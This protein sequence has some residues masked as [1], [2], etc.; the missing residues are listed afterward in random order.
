MFQRASVLRT[1]LSAACLAVF[2]IALLGDDSSGKQEPARKDL[3]GDSLPSGALAR[4]GTLRWRHGAKVTYVACLPDGKGVITADAENV[5]RL[6]DRET[7]KEIRRFTPPENKGSTSKQIEN[8]N[9]VLMLGG[10]MGARQTVALSADGKF[11]AAAHPGLPVQL[12]DVATGKPV[13]DIKVPPGGVGEFV[14]TADSKLIVGRGHDDTTYAWETDTGK[15]VSKIKLAKSEDGGQLGG[16]LLPQGYWPAGDLS[17]SPDGSNIAW[18]ETDFGNG[19]PTAHILIAERKTGK[20]VRRIKLDANNFMAAVLAFSPD[21]KTFAYATGDALHLCAADS[22]KEL[23][24]IKDLGGLSLILF[25]PDSKTLLT[26]G[27][28]G[29]I[30]LWNAEKREKVREID[31]PVPP[32][33]MFGGVF[34]IGAGM[35]GA[36]RDIAFASDGK[37]IAV[38]TGHAV[39]F[40]STE[41]GKEVSKQTGHTSPVTQVCTAADGK[42]ILSRGADGTIRRWDASTG[43]ELSSFQAPAGTSC[44]AASPDGKTVALGNADNT[45]RVCDAAS[46]KE[47]QKIA[48]PSTGVA[49]VAFSRDGKAVAARGHGKTNLG[50]YEAATGKEIKSI[51]FP[52]ENPGGLGGVVF[53][54]QGGG[55]SPGPALIF[56]PDGSTL[57]SLIGTSPV[58]VQPGANEA[59]S[60]ELFHVATGKSRKIEL[61]KE[62]VPAH[63]VYSPDGRTLAVEHADGSATIVEVASGHERCHLV[64]AV[65]KPQPTGQ[66]GDVMMVN[67]IG[68]FGGIG[69]SE[70]VAPKL[71]FAPDGRK[72]AL[73]QGREIT[74]FDMTTG[75]AIKSIKGHDGSITSLAFAPDGK[76][77]ATG[78]SD[79][80]LLLW[81]TS[82]L[83]PNKTVATK[84]GDKEVEAAWANL[85]ASDA[86]KADDSIKALVS[87]RQQATDWLKRYLTPLTPVEKSILEKR[88]AE[89]DSEDFE[90]RTKAT[91]DLEKLGELAVPALEKALAAKPSLEVQKRL[92]ELID[93]TVGGFHTGDRLRIVRAIE[94]LEKIDS[95]EAR[96]L[97]ESLA[98]GAP[99]ALQTENAQDALTRMKK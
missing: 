48:G 75:K 74:V 94:V 53:L 67:V 4:L 62:H 80:T 51:T 99:G 21:G 12:W 32:P 66:P 40:F 34:F 63:I 65:N 70:A 19:Q 98:K 33:S 56:S 77:L 92:E 54:G 26:R 18:V 43:K 78:S 2:G 49:V 71:A 89:L 15:E 88:I 36:T 11:L 59:A 93:K 20:E 1:T 58:F 68:G 37:T 82:D 25:S 91:Q 69:G 10:P 22:G 55:A 64:G 72:L 79:T 73:A 95:P 60:I 96:E 39:R 50:I 41:S 46:G 38:G 6:W 27:G 16:L 8:F 84:L 28:D 86:A 42:T 13:R 7:G 31:C 35:M 44:F 30:I 5:L 57:A 83:L 87:S 52:E 45:V 23:N 9:Q 85:E 81:D 97:L 90:T 24:E 17:V 47:L 29:K 3:A 76:S 61:P 14:F